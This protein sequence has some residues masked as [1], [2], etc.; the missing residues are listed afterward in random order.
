VNLDLYQTYQLAT[1]RRCQSRHL[2]E[3]ALARWDESAHNLGHD[4]FK[5]RGPEVVRGG[6]MSQFAT[7]FCVILLPILPAYILF[8]ALPASG[9]VDGKLQ[10][11][12]IKLSGAFA[13][14]FAVVLLIV[15]NQKALIPAQYK[16]WTVT[17]QVVDEKG[18]PI[19]PLAYKNISLQPNPLTPI[20]PGSF[21]L[22]FY[23]TPSANGASPTL[24]ISEDDYQTVC[25]S[26][27]KSLP[28][29]PGCSSEVTVSG[30]TI[31][32]GKVALK[33]LT[34]YN[35][36]LPALNSPTYATQ[37]DAHAPGH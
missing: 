29:A 2:E 21:M 30:N 33:K 9:S 27:D 13:G 4:S 19:D 7:L 22:T 24:S 3:F 18:H 1:I 23:S 6:D 25:Y 17:G 28:K 5:D 31:D 10:G 35:D 16:Q 20:A 8:K 32:V 26:L 34:P 15:A 14:Y 36:D 12:E 37:G 11:L